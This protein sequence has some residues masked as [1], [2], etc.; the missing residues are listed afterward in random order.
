[1]NITLLGNKAGVYIDSN[2]RAFV[3]YT[4]A[5]NYGNINMDN[6]SHLMIRRSDEGNLRIIQA[7]GYSAERGIFI[8]CY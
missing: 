3:D 4:T 1:M 7:A 5:T 2:N 8:D 6:V